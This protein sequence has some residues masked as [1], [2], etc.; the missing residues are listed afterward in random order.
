M[1]SPKEGTQS[2][3]RAHGNMSD[4]LDLSEEVLFGMEEHDE[5]EKAGR[6]VDELERE[7]LSGTD[8]EKQ[9]SRNER[10]TPENCVASQY[11][12]PRTRHCS[13]EARVADRST[14]SVFFHCRENRS[15]T[16]LTREGEPAS[17]SVSPERP[18]PVTTVQAVR[19]QDAVRDKVDEYVA[20]GSS[21]PIKI[22]Q[23]SL[24]TK[25]DGEVDERS[26]LQMP[27]TFVPPH[28]LEE[29]H[30]QTLLEKGLSVE[31]YGIKRERLRCR[32][33]ILRSTGFLEPTKPVS[34]APKGAQ[35]SV[36]QGLMSKALSPTLSGMAGT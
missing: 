16:R 33:A 23:Y 12:S 17:G 26:N 36:P 18:S 21:M 20:L 19:I 27:A 31:H 35:V 6:S 4:E 25:K 10:R 1:T 8:R 32:A 9:D 29:Q 24:K 34:V 11:D 7:D 15:V 30:H 22:P 13:C 2:S 28:L 3:T 5:G 14:P